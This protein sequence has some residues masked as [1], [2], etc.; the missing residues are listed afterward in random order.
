MPCLSPSF[1]KQPPPGV[2]CLVVTATFFERN[3]RLARRPSYIG[4]CGRI[5]TRT[6]HV[7]WIHSIDDFEAGKE[8]LR[9]IMPSAQ[10]TTLC[11][12]KA[13]ASALRQGLGRG[14]SQRIEQCESNYSGCVAA[15]EAIAE[16]WKFMCDKLA[17][18]QQSR[19]LRD[20]MGT[21]FVI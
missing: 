13:W 6:R 21:I 3:L 14:P 2:V 11:G 10:S 17:N 12:E 16:K 7:V 1:I 19:A 18:T 15:S 8:T 5:G 4:I 9:R 20:S